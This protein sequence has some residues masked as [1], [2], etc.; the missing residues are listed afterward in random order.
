MQAAESSASLGAKPD[1]RRDRHGER[2]QSRHLNRGKLKEGRRPGIARPVLRWDTTSCMNDDGGR[3]QRAKGAGAGSPE[4]GNPLPFA[5]YSESDSLLHGSCWPVCR[6]LNL[7]MPLSVSLAGCEPVLWRPWQV[8]GGFRHGSAEPWVCWR[9]TCSSAGHLRSP[10][11]GRESVS[12]S[13]MSQRR[14]GD[15]SEG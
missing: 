10:T 9:A 11:T 8:K 1:G 15:P 2:S 4:A 14:G 6:R 12:A 3:P 7:L 13:G 5:S